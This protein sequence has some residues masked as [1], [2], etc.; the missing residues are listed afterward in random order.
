MS[1]RLVLISAAKRKRQEPVSRLFGVDPDYIGNKSVIL[2]RSYESI[3]NTAFRVFNKFGFSIQRA[4][5]IFL[6][7]AICKGENKDTPTDTA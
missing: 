3:E 5:R 2:V 6:C 1:P 4:V 7:K